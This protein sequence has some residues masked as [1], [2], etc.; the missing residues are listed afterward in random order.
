[1]SP[2]EARSTPVNLDAREASTHRVTRNSK[3]ACRAEDFRSVASLA[4]A[5]DA[6]ED[7][8]DDVPERRVGS[9]LFYFLA[10][11]IGQYHFNDE[12]L[13]LVY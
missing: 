11:R 7:E 1:M 8:K 13:W 6:D 9:E 4:S 2:I 10:G 5:F 3:C 12:A